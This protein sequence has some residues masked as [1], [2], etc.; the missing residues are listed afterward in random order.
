MPKVSVICATHN[1]ERFL[2]ESIRSIL[3]QSFTDF[4]LLLFDDGSTDSTL[5]ILER[6]RGEDDRI[7]VQ[8]QKKQGLTKTLN[9]ALQQSTGSYV[10]RHDDDDISLPARL[11]QQV[12][13]LDTH[14]RCVVVGSR[15]YQIDENGEITGL[16][17]VPSADLRIK[18]ALLTHNVV[19]HSAASYRRSEVLAIG[20]YDEF[21]ETA[22][23]YDLWCRVA[24]HH[25][26]SN[27]EIPLLERRVHTQQVGKRDPVAQ[28][29]NR[30]RIR[31]TYRDA[32]LAGQYRADPSERAALKGLA[33]FHD[34]KDRAIDRVRRYWQPKWLDKL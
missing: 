21:F 4:E 2:N 6:L 13:R 19:A 33:L 5:D 34:R 9:R 26:L 15:Y 1:G 30:N 3:D 31:R 25:E 29:A 18:M 27:L 20:G 16:V 7:V 10:A 8:S 12:A 11:E 32:I 28:L 23:D 24:L 22:Q 14:P 17:R